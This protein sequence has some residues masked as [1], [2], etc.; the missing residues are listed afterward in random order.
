MLQPQIKAQTLLTACDSASSCEARGAQALKEGDVPTAIKC[1]RL[2]VGFAEDANSPLQ[3]ASAYNRM[4][5]AYFQVQDY[6]R[7]L[8]WTRLAL[9]IDPQ[10]Q[11]AKHAFS[12]IQKHLTDWPA[13]PTGTYVRYSGRGIWDTLCLTQGLSHKIRF[14]LV[15]FRVGP[16]WREFGPAAYG[17]I[18]GDAAPTRQGSYVLKGFEDFP[19][20]RVE[21][22]L[23]RRTATVLEPTGDCG[24]GQGVRAGGQYDRISATMPDLDQCGDSET[25]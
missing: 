1:F 23:R 14:Q 20:C 12:I 22:S 2:Q 4:S 19:G 11:P 9:R 24:F 13:N 15:A 17:D 18:L 10:N 8:S 3:I 25:P 5:Q 16:A 21:L 7:A 6:P